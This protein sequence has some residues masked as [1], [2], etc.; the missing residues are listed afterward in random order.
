MKVKIYF[1]LLYSRIEFPL[2]GLENAKENPLNSFSLT[3]VNKVRKIERAK[4]NK[5]LVCMIF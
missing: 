5:T 2:L 1:C 3:S 4:R